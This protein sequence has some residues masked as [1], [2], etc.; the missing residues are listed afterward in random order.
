M[1]L[2][3][4]LV[5]LGVC[6]IPINAS[7]CTASRHTLRVL[8]PYPHHHPIPPRCPKIHPRNPRNLR[9]SPVVGPAP[10]YPTVSSG[11]SAV[12]SRQDSTEIGNAGAGP[13]RSDEP[14]TPSVP[15]NSTLKSH[16]S[17]LST[18]QP[19]SDKNVVESPPSAALPTPNQ[20]PLRQ[21]PHQPVPAP[22]P[23][24]NPGVPRFPGST[25]SFLTNASDFR[26]RDIHYYEAFY[27]P[28]NRGSSA[29]DNSIDGNSMPKFIS[30]H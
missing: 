7:H 19:R 14:P 24:D 16:G 9:R 17:R 15:G 4:G 12:D 30:I 23:D 11:I 26:M 22:Q 8:A 13:S 2:F 29:G 27:L 18:C 25:T 10:R 6:P 3:V 28:A 5:T 21:P 20:H 1:C